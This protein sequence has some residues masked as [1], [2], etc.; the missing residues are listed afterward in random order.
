MEATLL[1]VP[2]IAFSLATRQDFDFDVAARFA[3]ELVRA[4]VSQE[5]PAEL[6]LNVNVPPGAD[7]D[8]YVVTRLGKH[9]YG[10]EVVVNTDPRGREY[11]WIGGNEYSHEDIEGS[12]CRAVYREGR[13]SVTP[14]HLQ[15]TDLDRIDLVRGWDVTAFTAR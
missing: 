2:A 15:Q 11:F 9:S 6:L 12:D 1:G 14:L 3:R 7:V 4:A 5:L 13:I 8:A 10:S